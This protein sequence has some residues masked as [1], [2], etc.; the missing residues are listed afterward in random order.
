MVIMERLFKVV[1]EFGEIEAQELA[2][3]IV[4]WRDSDSELSIPL[5][6]AEDYDYRNLSYP[7][8]AKDAEFEVLEELL[9]VKGMSEDILGKIRDYISI[10]GEGRVNVNTA[11][12]EIFL[13][14]G[15]DEDLTDKLV[16]FRQ[17]EDGVLGTDD[18]NIFQTTS[19]IVPRLSQEYSLS[20]SEVAQLSAV[21]SESLTTSSS[22]FLAR[23][24]AKLNNRENTTEIIS[25]FDRNGKILYWQEF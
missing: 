7:Y 11:P 5:G 9:L 13:A 21:V 17:G 10:Y 18:D 8:E 24:V 12:G 14:L 19:E 23:S 16:T 1:L 2:A 15:L 25:V 4:D 3:C 6:S 22:N 20:I